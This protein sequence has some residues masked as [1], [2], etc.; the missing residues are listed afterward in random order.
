MGAGHELG[1]DSEE[2]VAVELNGQDGGDGVGGP[3]ADLAGTVEVE[4]GWRGIEA[5]G[6]TENAAEAFGVEKHG[7]DLGTGEAIAHVFD[8]DVSITEDPA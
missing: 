3:G 1:D 2:G 5:E 7:D 8:L 6:G 4:V